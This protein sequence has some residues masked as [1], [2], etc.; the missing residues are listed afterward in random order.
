MSKLGVC[1][2]WN[3]QGHSKGNSEEEMWGGRDVMFKWLMVVF[4]LLFAASSVVMFCVFKQP[5][6]AILQMMLV[7]VLE[8]VQGRKGE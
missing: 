2:R 5:D 8:L 6:A 3:K 7:I 4:E 1:Q